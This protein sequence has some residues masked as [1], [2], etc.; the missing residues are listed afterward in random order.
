MNAPPLLQLW[1]VQRWRAGRGKVVGVQ[2]TRQRT[3]EPEPGQCPP[4]CAR[5]E[6]AKRRRIWGLCML[7]TSLPPSHLASL[8][9]SVRLRR[10][11]AT[12][13]IWARASMPDVAMADACEDER[14]ASQASTSDLEKIE[15]SEGGDPAKSCPY[16]L[17]GTD[18]E[19]LCSQTYD[20]QG[21]PYSRPA[22]SFVFLDGEVRCWALHT[23]HLA[24]SRERPDCVCAGSDFPGCPL[25]GTSRTGSPAARQGRCH[26]CGWLQVRPL[27]GPATMP[28]TKE[29]H[30]RSVAGLQEAL[31]SCGTKWTPVLVSQHQAKPLPYWASECCWLSGEVK[32]CKLPALHKALG[33]CLASRLELGVASLHR[34]C[35]T[36]I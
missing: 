17:Q 25:G 6:L 11:P 20:C 31:K 10:R 8:P 1:A 19:L 2:S 21:Y 36:S 28:V 3:P 9:G 23:L 24:P 14:S 30:V 35:T 12:D 27:R 33:K 22:S 7:L 4:P 26:R 32:H 13:R 15:A 18:R 16:Y 34:C 5:E 29:F